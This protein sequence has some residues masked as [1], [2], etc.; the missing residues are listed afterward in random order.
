M[1]NSDARIP[2]L[3]LVLSSNSKQLSMVHLSLCSQIVKS[4]KPATKT[5]PNSQG[6]HQVA[7]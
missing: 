5:H 6:T 4:P 2:A 1:D 3:G 7:W